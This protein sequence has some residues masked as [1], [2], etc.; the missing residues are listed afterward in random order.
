MFHGRLPPDTLSKT[1]SQAEDV[2]FSV[3]SNSSCGK[4]DSDL[5]EVSVDS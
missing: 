2:A 5:P 1:E 4:F 3:A